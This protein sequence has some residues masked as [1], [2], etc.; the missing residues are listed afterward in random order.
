[1]KRRAP[2]PTEVGPVTLEVARDAPVSG[3]KLPLLVISHGSGGSHLG[4]RDTAMYLAARGYVV[5]AVLHP[6]NNFQ[7]NHAER[8]HKNW[9][10]RPRHVSCALDHLLGGSRFAAVIDPEAVAVLGHSAGGYTALALVGGEPDL[11]AIEPHCRA[12]DDEAFCGGP[13]VL[14]WLAEAFSASGAPAPEPVRGMRDSRI[15]AAILLAPVGVLFRD[16]SSLAGVQ[17]PVLLFRAERDM[18]LR[19]PYHAEVIRRNLPVE[20]ECV[21]VRN[22]GHYCF[23]IP[24]PKDGGRQPEVAWDPPG[25]DRAAFHA[26]MNQRV[27]AFLSRIFERK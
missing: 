4:H 9:V 22:A 13:S 7:D 19:Y 3:R 5:A 27:E 20:P 25:F 6:G 17:V 11:S 18:V 1:M 23:L 16:E 26:D 14:V 15:K 2:S 12:H 24:A 10:D 8:T 21:V